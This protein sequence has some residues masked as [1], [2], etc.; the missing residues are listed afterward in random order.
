MD[1]TPFGLDI[2]QRVEERNDVFN[3][4]LLDNPTF[5]FVSLDMLGSQ[6]KDLKDRD[7]YI[8]GPPPMLKSLCA[9]AEQLGIAQ[10]LHYEEFSY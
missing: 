6:L 1:A 9:E 3:V 5:G 7:I 10:N 8:C 2:L 4:T